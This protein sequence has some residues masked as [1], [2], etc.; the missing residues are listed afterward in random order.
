M[1]KSIIA[2]SVA[3]LVLCCAAAGY[4]WYVNRDKRMVVELIGNVAALAEKESSKLPHAG[5]LKFSKVDDLF[6]QKIELK[7]VDPSISSSM[8]RDDLKAL[9]S[10]MIKRIDHMKVNTAN[11]VVDIAGDNATF[12]FDAEFSGVISGKKE[13]FANVYQISGTAVKSDGKWL[14]SSLIAE[15]IIQ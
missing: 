10:L 9:V 6:A 2:V 7:C 3:A 5:V 12:S 15:Q 8:S 13:E 4:F 1:K 11:I 14:I